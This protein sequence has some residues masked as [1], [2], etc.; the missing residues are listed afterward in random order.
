[1][2]CLREGTVPLPDGRRVGFAENGVRGGTPILH[3]HGLPGGRFYSLD[4]EALANA[5]AWHFCLE[6]PGYGLSDPQPGRRLLDWPADVASFADA[7]GIDRF[8]VVGTSAGAPYAL[9]C[10]YALAE[11]A[12]AVALQCGWLADVADS[13]LDELLRDDWQAPIRRYR[14]DPEGVLAEDQQRV[15]QRAAKWVTDPGGLFDDLFSGGTDGE[16]FGRF[17]S[18]W[19]RILAATY[20]NAPS[21]DEYRV[22]YE[23][24][25]FG[26][27][28]VSVPV[29]AW[30]G[31]L[32]DIRLELVQR[33]LARA[34]NASVT[35]CPGE[36]HYLD[37]RHDVEIVEF[38]TGWA[39]GASE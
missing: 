25:G 12:T 24:W 16:S 38:A 6:R 33:L 28:D 29:H 19:M 35:V 36:A 8:A 30:H 37:S 27:A 18:R 10:G 3:F 11:R 26:L 21:T 32:D 34:P 14:T 23:P 31:D 22:M 15:D 2:T 13:T 1:M 7:M 39:S 20:G 4:P 5:G 9:A 17:R